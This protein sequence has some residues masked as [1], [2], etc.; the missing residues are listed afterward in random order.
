MPASST[1]TSVMIASVA[2]TEMLPVAVDPYGISPSRFGEQDE[3][4]ERQDERR[5]AFAVVA[6]VGER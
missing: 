2:V 4:E 1:T 6:D 5:V 3:E